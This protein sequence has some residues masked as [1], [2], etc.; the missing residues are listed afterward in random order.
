MFGE[1]GHGVTWTDDNWWNPHAPDEYSVGAVEITEF[2]IIPLQFILYYK[3]FPSS[4]PVS[5]FVLANITYMT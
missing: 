4:L 2:I 1:G 3:K 5:N